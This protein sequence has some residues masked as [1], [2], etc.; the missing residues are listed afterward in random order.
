MWALRQSYGMLRPR[1]GISHGRTV[2]ALGRTV[3]ERK[4][5]D[6]NL[7]LL[8]ILAMLIIIANHFATKAGW[9]HGSIFASDVML[10]FLVIGGKTGV[11]VFILITGYFM[12][13]STFKV[14][15]L[16]RVYGETIFYSLLFLAV[17][18]LGRSALVN[19]ERVFNGIFPVITGTY[20]FVAAYIGLYLLTP[21]LNRAVHG[22]SRAAYGRLL[23][24]LFIVLSVIP[25][26]APLVT[27]PTINAVD[28]VYAVLPWF[29]FMYL[30]GGYIKLYGIERFSKR[31]W[32]YIL[33]ASTAFIFASMFGLEWLR[34]VAH[35]A[36]L[37][38][39][40]FRNPNMIS[41]L[42]FSVSLFFVFKNMDIK[43][44]RFINAVA[45]TTFGVYLI[46]DNEFVSAWLWKHF[47]FAYHMQPLMFLA[48]AVGAVV[49]VFCV[50]SLADYLR[51]RLLE[52]PVFALLEKH[53][54]RRL[55]LADAWMNGE[56]LEKAES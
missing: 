56:D 40:Y 4:K 39:T 29:V 22:M 55:D 37:S 31:A 15:S 16:L 51:I 50:C 6:S 21:W 20:W 14:R 28:F 5:R 12:I 25:T 17:F 35:V 53:G 46:H 54:A 41:A 45:A 30:L 48:V 34:Q 26:L 44:N 49:A 27:S 42:I 47:K 24:L 11:N 32:S 38:P 52:K 8:R 1:H 43:H 2:V 23:I 18:V 10:D 36:Y 7:E 9:P 13:E 3:L 33:L 19:P